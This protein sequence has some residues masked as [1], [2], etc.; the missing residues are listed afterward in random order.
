MVALYVQFRDGVPDEDR[1]RLYQHA[2]LSLANQDALNAMEE[3]GVRITKVCKQ[4]ILDSS[5]CS[6]SSLQGQN[7]RDRKKIK[8]KSGDDEYE[9]SR[10]KPLLKT[11]IEVSLA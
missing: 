4:V 10:F 11:I 1:R 8:Q 6:S 2:K 3:L 9:L 7:D 5:E